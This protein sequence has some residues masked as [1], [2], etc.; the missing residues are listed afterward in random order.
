[1]HTD[2]HTFFFFSNLLY[3]NKGSNV[4]VWAPP[5][6]K[7][8]SV[9]VATTISRQV[10]RFRHACTHSR[11][12]LSKHSETQKF[13]EPIA[14]RDNQI[15]CLWMCSQIYILIEDWHTAYG[16]MYTCRCLVMPVYKC[17]LNRLCACVGVCHFLVQANVFV[18]ILW[19]QCAELGLWGLSGWGSVGLSFMISYWLSVEERE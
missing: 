8:G 13:S 14:H 18:V 10:Y 17:F 5:E 4:C 12:H 1:M 11:T 15:I 16:S 9:T 3:R 19:S 7:W 6:W 2:A